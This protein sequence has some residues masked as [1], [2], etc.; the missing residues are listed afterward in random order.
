MT[1]GSFAQKKGNSNK[2]NP[3]PPAPQFQFW[4]SLIQVQKSVMEQKGISFC[5]TS[6]VLGWINQIG[7]GW[8]S[9]IF[10]RN[11]ECSES[12][13]LVKWLW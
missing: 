10:H 6:L 1:L 3:S 7:A 11:T 8:D 2:T 4:F 5:V 9:V 12:D 13:S